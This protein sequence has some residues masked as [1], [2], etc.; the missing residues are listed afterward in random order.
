LLGVGSGLPGENLSNT[1][2]VPMGTSTVGT[3]RWTPK[4]CESS[5]AICLNF[6]ASIS[7]KDSIST[8][9]HIRSD[10]RSAKVTT[11]AGVPDPAGS[12]STTSRR[13]RFRGGGLVALVGGQVT[14]QQLLD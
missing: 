3:S 11:H 4:A 12:S 14:A 10:I 8:K 2:L 7:E 9:K 6:A 1:A 13:L 5:P